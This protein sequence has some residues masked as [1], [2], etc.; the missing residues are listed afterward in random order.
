MQPIRQAVMSFVRLAV[1]GL[2]YSCVLLLL[3]QLYFWVT[4]QTRRGHAAMDQL[5]FATDEVL[6]FSGLVLLAGSVLM[7]FSNRRLAG[8]GVIIAIL[9]ILASLISPVNVVRA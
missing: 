3:I 2:C 5:Y 9:S 4:F 8:W 6:F 1:R 7:S